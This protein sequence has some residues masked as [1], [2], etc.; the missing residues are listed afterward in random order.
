M[1]LRRTLPGSRL[2][3]EA[4]RVPCIGAR[5]LGCWPSWPLLWRVLAQDCCTQESQ[6]STALRGDARATP[7]CPQRTSGSRTT[8]APIPGCCRSSKAGICGIRPTG[9]PCT[10]RVASSSTWSN[11]EYHFSN[12]PPPLDGIRLAMGGRVI[13]L[14]QADGG[15]RQMI[16]LRLSA[17]PSATVWRPHPNLVAASRGFPLQYC[18]VILAFKARRV[19]PLSC[20]AARRKSASCDG[21]SD[22]GHASVESG[23]HTT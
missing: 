6:S 7:T 4:R 21:L 5:H 23:M 3:R 22:C 18:N 11:K 8:S 9:P 16:P 10:H 19:G 20:D 14:L 2:G 17:S 15:P 12:P 1:Q 13:L